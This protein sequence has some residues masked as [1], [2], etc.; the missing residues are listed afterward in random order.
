MLFHLISR[1]DWAA[2]GDPYSP[3]SLGT[4][5]FVHLSTAE[6]VDGTA[7]MFFAGRDDLLLLQ[8]TVPADDRL[9][10]WD[11]SIG[12]QGVERFPHYY[13][14]VPR[15]LVTAVE[16]WEAGVTTGTPRRIVWQESPEVTTPPPASAH[17]ARVRLESGSRRFARLGDPGSQLTRLVGP[18]AF[19][20]AP[21][22]D[23][24]QEPY[25]AVLGCSDARV[26]VELVLGAATNELFV[27]RV[28]GNVPGRECLGSLHYAAGNLPTVRTVVVLGHSGCGAVTA[29]A[30]ALLDPESYLG[31]VHDAP[32]RAIVDALL[33]GVRL[34]VRAVEQE[35]GSGLDVRAARSHLVEL[36]VTANAA[37]T[38]HALARDLAGHEGLEVVYATYDLGRRGVG[39]PGGGGWAA[40]LH[41]APRDEAEIDA[42]LRDAARTVFGQ[43]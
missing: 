43:R 17:E 9:L 1:A 10:R 20:L 41:D 34:A 32:L 28:A 16:P 33:A 5:G 3:A 19:G 40:G 36:A 30:D 39:R 13:G 18:E 15:S 2:A 38:A 26:P 11:E 21:D 14:P 12:P 4:E 35:F 25:A 29:A 7:A 31:I 8:I 22:G 24:A 6:Q 27:V 42:V 23:L 37:I